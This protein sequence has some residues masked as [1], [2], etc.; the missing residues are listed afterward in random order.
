MELGLE[1]PHGY[2]YEDSVQR[3]SRPLL[4]QSRRLSPDEKS[5]HAAS[6]SWRNWGPNK[7]VDERKEL[8]SRLF[9]AS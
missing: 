1:A 4:R 5:W 2:A 3:L 6:S 9:L 7:H 8:S